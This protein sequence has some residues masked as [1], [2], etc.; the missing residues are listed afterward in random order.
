MLCT[1]CGGQTSEAVC[2]HC[3]E[4]PLAC[5]RFALDEV[6]RHGDDFV[7]R[8]AL[9]VQAQDLVYL[10]RVHARLSE[11]EVRRPSTSNV[12]AVQRWFMG[13][14]VGTAG[15]SGLLLFGVAESVRTS[16][17]PPTVEELADLGMH[18]VDFAIWVEVARAA[19]VERIERWGAV[20]SDPY[21]GQPGLVVRDDIAFWTG[22]RWRV[23]KGEDSSLLS[24]NRVVPPARTTCLAQTEGSRWT[25]CTPAEQP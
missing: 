15:L 3:G 7:T 10:S 14:V 22:E 19:G 12:D 24:D 5:G 16:S 20:I 9:D 8:V 25:T 6:V 18:P 13:K 17:R 1:S 4:E 21:H 11:P 2:P 23:C